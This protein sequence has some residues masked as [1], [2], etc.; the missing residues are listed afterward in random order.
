L[1]YVTDPDVSKSKPVAAGKMSVT[2]LI[3]AVVFGLLPLAFLSWHFLLAIMPVLYATW[4]MSK[5]FKKWIGGYT[6]DCLGA[7][8]QVSEI[9][10]YL[11]FIV[12]WRYL[13]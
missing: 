1:D 9:V 8:Q 2:A 6:G 3:M 4:S 12:I 7:I 5:Y 11:S 13:L 10:F